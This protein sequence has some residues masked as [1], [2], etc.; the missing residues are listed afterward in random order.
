MLVTTMTGDGAG[1]IDTGMIT[2]MRKRS[3]SA[4]CPGDGETR[5]A[6]EN[7]TST[8]TED[9]VPMLPNVD[10]E[11]SMI[12][13]IRPTTAGTQGATASEDEQRKKGLAPKITTDMT[14]T[15]AGTATGVGQTETGVGNRKR[16]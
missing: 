5:S 2:T 6:T 12:G 16:T 9:T 8:R 10:Q 11:T 15:I 1:V 4:L 13:A 14:S 3:Q 7:E